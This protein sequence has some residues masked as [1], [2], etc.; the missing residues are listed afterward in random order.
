MAVLLMSILAF[1]LSLTHTGLNT[2]PSPLRRSPL[3]ISV[4]LALFAFTSV[5]VQAAP[6]FAETNGDMPDDAA[7]PSTR[8]DSYRG[9]GDSL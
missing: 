7:M 2:H 4:A 1:D 6:I 5:S 8:L 9:N 3:A